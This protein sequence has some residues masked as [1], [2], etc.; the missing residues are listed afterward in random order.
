MAGDIRGL[1]QDKILT[2]YMRIKG[3]W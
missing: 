3:L 1:F 2:C